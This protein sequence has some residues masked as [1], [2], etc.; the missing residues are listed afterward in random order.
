[1][2][3]GIF[4]ER[5][6]Y[7][8]PLT[9]LPPTVT[10]AGVAYSN[11]TLH[12]VTF[13]NNT[14]YRRYWPPENATA[15]I[16]TGAFVALSTSQPEEIATI[17]R[18][19]LNN[20]DINF[21]IDLQQFDFLKTD[22]QLFNTPPVIS[23]LAGAQFKIFRNV[24][25]GVTMGTGA[26]YV[27]TY[28]QVSGILDPRWEEVMFTGGPILT[29]GGY[30]A[31]STTAAVPISFMMD[32]RHHYQLVEILA[33]PTHQVPMGQWRISYD[34]NGDIFFEPVLIGGI[35][36]PLLIRST[37]TNL[38]GIT[39]PL[40]PRS[41]LFYLGNWLQ[42]QLPHTGGSG[43]MII[44]AIGGIFISMAMFVMF[45]VLVAKK[46]SVLA[47]PYKHRNPNKR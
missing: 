42:I 1:M 23:L 26:G 32:P 19:P 12:S 46:K 17:R 16:S 38:A 22:E 30:I 18:H 15:A 27:V 36:S 29:S 10:G 7:A 41:N 25:P 4:T 9:H 20:N 11:L 6:Q 28:D 13:G 45:A 3:G 24:D 33:P 37:S 40:S 44:A 47:S 35:P 34:R 2:G 5:F 8:D 43:I 14:S 21:R 39:H 31:Q